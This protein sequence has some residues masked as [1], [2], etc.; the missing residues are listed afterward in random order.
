MNK[1]HMFF[2]IGAAICLGGMLGDLVN[3]IMAGLRGDY[4]SG[5]LC[6]VA[7]A[8]NLEGWQIAAKARDETPIY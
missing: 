7:A 8:L 2:T 5:V 4:W 3:M 1:S 6:G